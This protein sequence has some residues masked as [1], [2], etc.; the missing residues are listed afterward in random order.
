M[1]FAESDYGYCCE[2]AIQIWLYSDL[3]YLWIIVLCHLLLIYVE[4]SD[5]ILQCH[6]W[7]QYAHHFCKVKLHSKV[8]LICNLLLYLSIYRVPDMW[9]NFFYDGGV[10]F[11]IK[12]TGS[13]ISRG[14]VFLFR[15]NLP[16]KA[17]GWTGVR[18]GDRILED[19]VPGSFTEMLHFCMLVFWHTERTLHINK[20]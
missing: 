3:F 13:W 6:R 14:F 16:S 10:A 18:K 4:K 7:P 15:N 1:T 5:R 17:L 11:M 9:Y 8:F 12:R 2:Y 19:L 20:R